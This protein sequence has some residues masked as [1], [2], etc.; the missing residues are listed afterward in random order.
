MKEAALHDRGGP[1][2]SGPIAT[3]KLK[4]SMHK[5]RKMIQVRFVTACTS[6]HI[7][8]FP[9][10]DWVFKGSVGDITGLRLRLH[11]SGSASLAGVTVVCEKDIADIAIVAKRPLTGVF[12]SSAE[13][14]QNALSK[15]GVLCQGENPV[16]GYD[17]APDD[18]A[19]CGELLNVLIKGSSNIYF[20][21]TVSSIYI[22]PIREGVDEEILEVL[23]DQSVWV[24]LTMMAAVNDGKVNENSVEV[25]LK[26]YYP[27]LD[28]VTADVVRAANEKLVDDAAEA[29]DDTET[30][31]SEESY[32][33]QEYAV[34]RR[35]IQKGYPKTDLI[36]TP[37]KISDYENFL[38][39]W[40]ERLSLVPKLRETRAF[41]G[42]SRIRP[43]ES[44]TREK[45]FRLISRDVKDWLPAVVV[46]GEGLFFELDQSRLLTWHAE[47]AS[48]IDPRVDSI[49]GT[50]SDLK[51]RRG[52]GRDSVDAKFLVVHT[53]AHLLINQLIFDCGYGSASLRERIYCSSDDDEM[54]G[55]LIYTAAGDSEGT[56]GGLVRMG[57]PGRFESVFRRALES[58]RWC[59]SDPICIESEGQ[60]PDNCNLAACHACS[61]LPET[62]CE[63][64]NK[65]LDR[66]ILVGD[67][68]NPDAGFFSSYFS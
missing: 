64:Q 49:N 55:V 3:G 7:R 24:A 20:P 43:Q 52:F 48:F 11:T 1:T 62:S 19:G 23:E 17:P 60:G 47:N 10:W 58:A 45:M 51:E 46:R 59:S 27:H 35:K 39:S 50:L 15:I 29:N 4:G 16:L 31:V 12:G 53:L 30:D 5:Q 9:W 34:L 6:G 13:G 2:C 56:L 44:E 18:G 25:A 66:G 8:D 67:L 40:F 65:Y 36:V 61:L 37:K 63:V 41:V 28:L 42:F 54:V 32:R 26:K 21:Q 57:E 33:Q 22:P 68:Q 14:D 38:G